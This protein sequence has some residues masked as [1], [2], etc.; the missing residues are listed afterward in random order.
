MALAVERYLREVRLLPTHSASSI[1]WVWPRRI[2]IFHL[3]CLGWVF[4]R[5][6]SLASAASLL[7]GLSHFVWEPEYLVAL[8]FLVMFAIP[9]FLVDL[10][11]EHTG[12]EYMFQE[13]TPLM[14]IATACCVVVLIT[15]F[16]ANQAN[17]FIYF[18]F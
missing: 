8:K 5:A 4:F 14:R 18:Q 13:K 16:S 17:A 3:V 6:D 9:I 11:L 15:F 10:H 1:D 7:R 12:Q 2:F